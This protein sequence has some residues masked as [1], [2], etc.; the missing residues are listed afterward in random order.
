MERTIHVA[1]VLSWLMGKWK[2]SIYCYTLSRQFDH[3]SHL[4]L[5][6]PPTKKCHDNK[7]NIITRTVTV[8]LRTHNSCG[9]SCIMA[10]GQMEGINLFFI[11]CQDSLIMNYI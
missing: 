3:E 4:I 9:S 8:T 1:S 10:H 11:L 2:G 6:G 7:A 5:A